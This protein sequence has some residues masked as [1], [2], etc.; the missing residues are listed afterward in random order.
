MRLRRR[1]KGERRKEFRRAQNCYTWFGDTIKA[2]TGVH[3]LQHGLLN[4]MK[5]SFGS[6]VERWP[7]PPSV[8]CGRGAQKLPKCQALCPAT[9]E[10]STRKEKQIWSYIPCC[11]I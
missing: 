1:L 5:Q 3:R 10:H 4:E 2:Y 9:H 7:F 11:T 8:C 6:L